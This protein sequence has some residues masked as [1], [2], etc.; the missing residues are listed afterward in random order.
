MP[1]FKVWL[2]WAILVA[3]IVLLLHL[4]DN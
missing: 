1:H 2:N 4:S 3:V